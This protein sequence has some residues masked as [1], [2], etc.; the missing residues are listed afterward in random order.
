M[1]PCKAVFGLGRRR[2][3]QKAKET[4][5][6]YKSKKEL[7]ATISDLLPEDAQEIYV[8][9]YNRMW[10]GAGDGSAG[11]L[12]RHGVAHRQGWAAVE[13]KFAQDPKTGAWHRIG[14]EAAEEDKGLFDRAKEVIERIV[15]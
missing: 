7:P 6:R 10:D 8:E 5:M 15:S 9:A 12:S 2:R 4:D 1:G 11:D 14:D 3:A 13:R